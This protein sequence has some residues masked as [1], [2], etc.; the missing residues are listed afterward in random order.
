MTKADLPGAE[1]GFRTKLAET[2]GREVLLF[3][4]VTGQG[5]NQL[6]AAVAAALNEPPAW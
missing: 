6:L 2:L 3:S 1:E 4:A 5:L